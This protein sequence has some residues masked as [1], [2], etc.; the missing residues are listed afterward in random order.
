M[1][2]GFIGLGAMGRPMTLHLMKHGHEMGV[3][4]RRMESASP[5][6]KA[7][8][9]RYDTPAA[10]AAA[11]EVVFTMVTHSHDVEAV[12]LGA[13]AVDLDAVEPKHLLEVQFRPQSLEVYP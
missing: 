5:L 9:K 2:L 11:C 3:Y 6:V 4:A 1:K 7:G 13:L 10:L 8:A 12:V